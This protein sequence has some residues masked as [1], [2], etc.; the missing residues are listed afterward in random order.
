MEEQVNGM[1]LSGRNE[2]FMSVPKNKQNGN[3]SSDSF[4]C[5]AMVFYSS[6]CWIVAISEFL[7]RWYAK[8]F[9]HPDVVAA[10][11]YIFIW[12]EDLGVEHF[13]AEE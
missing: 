1:S 10:Y 9:L 2:L 4:K 13:E 5:C 11:D 6:L 7:K 12:D 3:L 8:R